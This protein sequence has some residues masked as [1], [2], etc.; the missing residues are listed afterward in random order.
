[1][2]RRIL[3]ILIAALIVI[4]VIF[5]GGCSGKVNMLTGRWKLAT[6]GDSSGANQSEYPLPVII[7]IYPNGTI[8]MLE[9]PFGK[10]TMDRDTFTFK[11][12]DGSIDTSGSFKIEYV[13]DQESGGS[14]L[15]LT[16]LD[17]V[18]SASYILKKQ[19]DL[20]TL[21]SYKRAK[22]SAAPAPAK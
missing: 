5:I 19:A 8:D 17:D 10:W 14:V 7:D 21:E 22:A 18:L 13:A 16:V 15:T 3:A 6:I 9:M 11:S 12:N 2:R 1:M 20:K 4:S